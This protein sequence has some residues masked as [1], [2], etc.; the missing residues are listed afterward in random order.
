MVLCD[1]IKLLSIPQEDWSKQQ[2]TQAAKRRK[3]TT[4]LSDSD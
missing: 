2:K 1:F 4:V 3:K